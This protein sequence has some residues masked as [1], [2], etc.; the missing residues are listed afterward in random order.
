MFHRKRRILEEEGWVIIQGWKKVIE[1]IAVFE[2]TKIK[3]GKIIENG[4]TETR[5]GT[6]ERRAEEDPKR[7][8]QREFIRVSNII[9]HPSGTVGESSAT[10]MEEFQEN[11][12]SKN[13]SGR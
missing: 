10:V 4:T 3:E 2:T 1:N 9:E 6:V 7:G 13:V 11:M 12:N 8:M 5:K